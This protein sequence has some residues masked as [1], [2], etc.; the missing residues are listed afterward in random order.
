MKVLI[1]FAIVLVAVHAG[2]KD[3]K[4][5][6]RKGLSI[7]GNHDC[8]CVGYEA[9]AKKCNWE[10]KIAK[11]VKTSEEYRHYSRKCKRIN[12]FRDGKRNGTIPN[13]YVRQMQC[14][15]Y[16]SSELRIKQSTGYVEKQ[17]TIKPTKRSLPQFVNNDN[18]N[19]YVGIPPIYY[20]PTPPAG[21][22][23]LNAPIAASVDWS[24]QFTPIKNQ[25]TC[26]SCWIFTAT[27]LCEWYLKNIS[28]KA[29]TILSEQ[30][31]VDCFAPGVN[32]CLGGDTKSALH[33]ISNSGVASSSYS[34]TAT[35]TAN[36]CKCPATYPQSYKCPKPIAEYWASG[37]DTRLRQV[38][39]QRPVAVSFKVMDDL[40]Q[41]TNG[42]YVP[43]QVC[44]ANVNH[45]VILVG[46]GYD[47]TSKRNFWKIRNSWG[48]DRGE[49]G[50]YR[51][52]AEKPFQCGI[53]RVF[54]Y[55]P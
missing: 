48:T 46:F 42:V 17:R 6:A 30:S 24:S 51:L 35:Y 29:Q 14:D 16:K 9:L 2:P 1:I 39:S 4:K 25:L 37:N 33:Y 40:Y 15:A 36:T 45:A 11:C 8:S 13:T 54:Y 28:P 20:N 31:V 10:A 21:M 44:D 43:T 50:Y 38:V 3:P 52:D 22:V 41:Y 47:T 18:T 19:S 34:Y 55:Y 12:N 26:G 23:S 32:T 5:G 27:G 7:K 53:S 49:Q